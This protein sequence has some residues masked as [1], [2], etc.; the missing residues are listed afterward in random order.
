MADATGARLS[1]VRR[2]VPRPLRRAASAWLCSCASAARMRRDLGA[3]AKRGCRSSPGHGSAKLA[4]SC[5]TGYRSCAGVPSDECRSG[6]SSRSRAAARRRG[7]GRLRRATR[8]CSSRSRRT[9]FRDQH[10][11]RV[12]ELGEQKQTRVTEFDRQPGRYGDAPREARA[13]W[14]LLHPSRMYELFNPYWWGHR[15]QQWV[16]AHARYATLPTPGLRRCAADAAALCGG[17]VLFQRLLSRR[18]RATARSCARCC[19]RWRRAALSSRCRPVSTSTI[20]TARGSTS[21]ACATC[22]RG[23][24]PARNLHVQSAIVARADAF[25]GTY[26]G[27][28]YMAPFYGLPS[29][30]FYS[31]PN[32]FS[33]KHLQMA[34]AAFERIGAPGLLDVRDVANVANVSSV[35][36]RV[37]AATAPVHGS[38]EREG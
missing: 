20:T 9:T 5:S 33:S 3:M 31:D 8:M 2:L 6:D 24:T 1:A 29:I 14:S 16:H 30:A 10:D 26:G 19:G 7:I 17:E 11:A 38:A 25:V 28:S 21:T 15:S 23:L 37:L 27:F 22:P 12:R 32:G 35:V 18:R 13:D 4:S 34:H 36:D